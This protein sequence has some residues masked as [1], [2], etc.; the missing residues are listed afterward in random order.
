MMNLLCQFKVALTLLAV[1]AACCRRAAGQTPAGATRPYP[2]HRTGYRCAFDS[3]QQAAYA[4]QPGAAAIYR[5]FLREVA[6]LPPAAQARLLA[7]P[8]VTVPQMNRTMRV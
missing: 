2:E 7:A 8:D 4:R 1:S 5:A 3:A 6:A